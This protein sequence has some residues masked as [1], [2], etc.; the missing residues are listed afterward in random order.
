M[1]SD[2]FIRN[3]HDLQ[4]MIY[5]EIDNMIY[6]EMDDDQSPTTL[7]Y[8]YISSNAKTTKQVEISYAVLTNVSIVLFR[9]LKR[10]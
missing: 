4:D 10:N 1:F 5:N 6:D 3:T 2:L 9:M 7:V 8:D